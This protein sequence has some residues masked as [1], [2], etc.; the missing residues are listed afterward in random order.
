MK[1]KSY[2]RN[3]P[4]EAPIAPGVPPSTAVAATA[5]T[6]TIPA[7]PTLAHVSSP[8]T[9]TVATARLTAASAVTLR[10]RAPDARRMR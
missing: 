8:H 5:T 3:A 2:S 4:I 6:Y 10:I 1:K 9:T 7:F